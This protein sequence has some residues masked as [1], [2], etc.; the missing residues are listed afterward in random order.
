MTAT[1]GEIWSKEDVPQVEEDQ[2]KEYLRKLDKSISPGGKHLQMPRELAD[3]IERLIL[4]IFD[5][6]WW[7][8]VSNNWRR[9]NVTPVFKKDKKEDQ[10]NNRLGQ[11]HL[12]PWECDRASNPGNNFQAH[13]RQENNQ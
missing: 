4:I 12:S 10:G 5:Q 2:V 1:G 11:H 9:A 3:A 7:L 8:T 6:S 13:E